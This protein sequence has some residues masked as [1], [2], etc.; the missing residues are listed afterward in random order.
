MEKIVGDALRKER[1]ARG[2]SLEEIANETRIGSRF[3]R[4]LEDEDF[5][6]FPGKFYIHYYIKNYLHACGA[7]ETAFFNTYQPYLQSVLKDSGAASPDQYLHKMSYTKFHKSRAIAIAIM[8]LVILALLAYLF[9]GPPRLVEKLLAGAQ[10]AF[11]IPA[12]SH[13]L[14]RPADDYC[15]DEAPLIANLS[16]A[17]PCWVQLL[18]GS[19]KIAEKIFQKGD[20]YVLQGY[21][22]TLVIEK[23]QALRLQLNGRDVSYLSRQAEALKLV[24]NPGNLAEIL[25]R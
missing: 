24:V 20:S 6:L 13:S 23:P 10:G 21:Q 2:V 22:L 15:L 14:L 19:E 12:F 17:F 1:E 11:A 9:F 25:R 16:F 18:R 4:A 8:A 3:L 5:G 7:D